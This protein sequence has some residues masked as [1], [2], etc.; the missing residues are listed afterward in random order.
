MPTRYFDYEN[1]A[2]NAK[3]PARKLARL[4]ALIRR[5]FPKD[6]MMFELHML[7]VCMSIRDGH[8]TID[9]AL[10]DESDAAA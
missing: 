8:L 4:H 3:I 7:R 10:A 1:V 2:R 6:D 5:E 9:E